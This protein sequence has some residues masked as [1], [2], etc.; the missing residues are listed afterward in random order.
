MVGVKQLQL[1]YIAIAELIARHALC[2]IRLILEQKK[3]WF[4]PAFFCL[5]LRIYFNKPCN[6]PFNL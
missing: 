6:K 1:F 4:N 3:G 5:S 2:N